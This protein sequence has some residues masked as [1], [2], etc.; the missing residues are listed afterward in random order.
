MDTNVT[1]NNTLQPYRNM[2]ED[3]WALANTRLLATPRDGE[4]QQVWKNGPSKSRTVSS[5]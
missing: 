5:V 2:A 4:C 3:L 1:I